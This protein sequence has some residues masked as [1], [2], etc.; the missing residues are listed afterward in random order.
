[1]NHQDQRNVNSQRLNI[2]NVL[3]SQRHVTLI[4]VQTST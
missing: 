4:V 3:P 2:S 1:V